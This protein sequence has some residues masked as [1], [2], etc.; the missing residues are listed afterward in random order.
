MVKLKAQKRK[1]KSE[2]GKAEDL[3]NDGF[4]PAVVYGPK[5]KP[6]SIS[7][8]A[9]DFDKT[10]EEA[11]ESTIVSLEIDG[12]EHDT[13]IHE[14][15]KDPIR[16][17]VTHVDFYAIER[18]KKLQVSVELVY[19]GESPADKNLGALIV[20]VMHEVEVE[21]LPR[22]LPSELKV[23]ISKLVQFND[24]IL[25]KDIKLPEG[26]ELITGEDEVITLAKEPKEEVVE[27]PEEMDLD[28]IEVEGEKKEGEEG[29]EGEGESKPEE[30]KEE[31]KEE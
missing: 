1:G 5:Q 29:E 14:V 25:A 28:S 20:K 9:L 11:G 2:K 19:E 4:I 15:Q 23:D 16:S 7:I 27:E 21:C 6:I 31:K 30:S 8:K 17:E 13:L 26:V 12:E 18:G 22:D 24:Q 3:R 10:Y